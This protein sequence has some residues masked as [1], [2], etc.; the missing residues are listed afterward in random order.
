M[1]SPLSVAAACNSKLNERQ[2]RLRSAS[3]Q[4]LL[5]RPPKGAWMISCIP[6][7]SSKKR[8]AMMQSLRRNLAQHRAAGDD[9]LDQLLCAGIVEPALVLQ[10]R[11][12]VCTSGLDS[13]PRRRALGAAERDVSPA[14]AGSG[15]KRAAWTRR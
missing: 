7:P 4:A 11:D 6:P 14:E 5:M 1:F 8:S 10:P 3:P 15:G 13:I 9:V 12:A 2:K